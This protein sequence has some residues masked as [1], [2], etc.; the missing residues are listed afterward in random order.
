M[1]LGPEVSSVEHD[2]NSIGGHRL[3][4]PGIVHNSCVGFVY[5]T[6]GD[7]LWGTN[8]IDR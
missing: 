1:E 6:G 7:R 3:S 8:Q 2:F 5:L 4:N